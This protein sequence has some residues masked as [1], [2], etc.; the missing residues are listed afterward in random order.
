[1]AQQ[2]LKRPDVHF[3]HSQMRSVG[4]AQVAKPKV[5]D[6]R[7]PARRCETVFNIPDMPAILIPENI[8]RITGVRVI[9]LPIGNIDIKC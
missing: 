9:F 7:L 1:M 3:P 4:M 2:F 8:A 5:R 6:A